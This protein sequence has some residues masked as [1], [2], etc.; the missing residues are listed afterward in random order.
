MAV[1]MTLAP[2]LMSVFGRLLF[3]P[4]PGR[5]LA[6]GGRAGSAP[7]SAARFAV[8]WPAALLAATLCAAGLL[9]IA[10][11]ARHPQL[12]SPLVNELP[13]SSAT[14]AQSAAGKGFAPGIV[15]PTD[16]LVIGPGV[17][18][19]RPALA[20]FQRELAAQPGVAET[21]GPAT[22]YQLAGVPRAA[23]NPLLAKSG[24][25]ARFVVVQDSD[26]LGATA[27]SQLRT[28]T[29][30][31]PSLA[32]SAGLARV[33]VEVGGET[34]LTSDAISSVLADLS[35]VVVAILA[36]S[37]L[38]LAVFLRSLLA[39]A[40]LLLASVLA[41]F[42]SLGLTLLL[43]RHFLGVASLVYFVPIAG[44]VLLV[45]LGSD[46]NV[47]VAGRIWEEARHR[48]LRDAV[49]VAVPRASR[50]ITTAGVALA[51]SFAMLAVIPLEQF[52]QI[53][54][55]MGIGVILDAVVVRSVLVPA[56]VVL[57]GRVGT[58]PALPMASAAAGCRPGGHRDEVAG[59]V[60]VKE[61]RGAAGGVGQ[62]DAVG[63]GGQAVRGGRLEA[64]EH[65]PGRV[66]VQF[67]PAHRSGPHEEIGD[68]D[69]GEHRADHVDQGAVGGDA[70]A[71]PPLLLRA[72][73]F[74][75]AGAGAAPHPP[76]P[77]GGARAG[78]A[79]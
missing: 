79:V 8:T 26:P 44:G 11:V 17:A 24:N 19:Q 50:A 33:R 5:R 66:D 65:R 4:E 29:D 25:A 62:L 10:A 47:F 57:F 70:K 71:G 23:P 76:G 22:L 35:R 31:L 39:P 75:T 46:Y 21:A 3:R 51:A 16:I 30:R 68:L 64:G 56:L 40:Y 48:P 54:L 15:A 38:L 1:S 60:R 41:V 36:V 61:R 45:S 9:A 77:R 59:V 74:G 37:L 53:A 58:W 32:R 69:R 67:H 14:S 42:A 27:I 28:L 49:R 6:P 7:D 18:G 73:Q 78:L 34:A 52:R 2:A 13:A 63:R 43:S 12:D 20:R 72:V 55:L